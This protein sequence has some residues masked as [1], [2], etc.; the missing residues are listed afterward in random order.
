MAEQATLRM[1]TA[2]SG[3]QEWQT[4]KGRTATII[5]QIHAVKNLDE[6]FF[7][8]KSEL[9]TLYD[10]EQLTLYAVDREKKELYSKY[11]L[12]LLDGVQEIRVPINEASISGYCARYGKILNIADAYDPA[13][14]AA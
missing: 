4:A 1:P 3:S 6:L 10:V 14:L 9:A 7:G 8:L 13:E 2:T 11:L 5:N 12:D